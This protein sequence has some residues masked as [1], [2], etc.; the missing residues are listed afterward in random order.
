MEL[1]W[2]TYLALPFDESFLILVAVSDSWVSLFLLALGSQS[3]VP[4]NL[5]CVCVCVCVCV[6]CVHV[7]GD[8]KMTV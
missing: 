4:C 1:K 3:L 5:V 2:C 8:V 6:W 7:C